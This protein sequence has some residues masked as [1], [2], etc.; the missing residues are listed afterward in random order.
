[1]PIVGPLRELGVHDVFQLLA[2][3]RK[4]GMLRVASN[5]HEEGFVVFAEGRVAHAGMRGQP[6][7][8]EDVLVSSGRLSALDVEHA[9]TLSGRNPSLTPLE[10]LIQAGAI[11][12]R[13]VERVVRQ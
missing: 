8:I 10:V 4:T 5:A 1:M 7:E 9:R 13:E 6:T 3:S 12:E 2:L 11:A